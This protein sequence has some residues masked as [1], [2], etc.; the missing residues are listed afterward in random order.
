VKPLSRKEEILDALGDIIQSKGINANFT[1]SELAHKVD[2]G[3][4][5]IYEYFTTKDELLSEAM[6]RVFKNAM[7]QIAARRLD[8][9]KSFEESL[10]DE[11]TFAFDLATG[12]SY[13]FKLLTPD[14]RDTIPS[15]MKGQF[16]EYM[17]KTTKQYEELF[18]NLVA[19][20]I[21]E[22]VLTP[23][24]LSV[25]AALFAALVSGSIQYVTRA[26][27]GQ[28]IPVDHHA[29]ITGIY[30]TIIHIFN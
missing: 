21:E 12:S 5:T 8:P 7:E 2:I 1:I 19:K 11:L 6:I 17:R 25:Q 23:K 20:G 4:S 18:R 28:A 30:N 22:G 27:N 10:K 3:K 26:E 14:F 9:S 29:F 24:D 16:A 15:N 13:I